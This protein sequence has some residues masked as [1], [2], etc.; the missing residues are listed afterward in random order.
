MC[1]GDSFNS[2]CFCRG[3]LIAVASAE[4]M[5]ENNHALGF[6]I[7]HTCWRSRVCVRG[8]SH[9]CQ[10]SSCH[11]T[12]MRRNYSAKMS[13][14]KGFFIFWKHHLGKCKN[15]ALGS[16][17]FSPFCF[18]SSDFVKLLNFTVTFIGFA[19]GNCAIMDYL[20]FPILFICVCF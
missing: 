5:L 19:P 13:F 20:K 1:A 8:Q 2:G 7:I 15:F 9:R 4:A 14:E 16:C 10:H 12:H 11:C 3:A 17:I 18:L 6:V